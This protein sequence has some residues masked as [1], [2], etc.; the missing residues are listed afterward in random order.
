MHERVQLCQDPQT[1]FALLRESLGA[2]RTN[3]ILSVYG[4]TNLQEQRAAEFF[5]ELGQRSLEMLFPGFMEDSMVQATLNAD[6]SG[7]GHKKAR[8]IAAPAHLGALIAARPRIRALIQDAVLAGLLLQQRL[9]TRLDAVIATATSTYTTK[10]E[11]R[12]S[13]MFRKRPGQQRKRGSKQSGSIMGPAS[14]TRQCQTSNIPAPP[15][16]MT[17]VRI[18]TSQRTGRADS[19]HRRSKRSFHGCVIRLGSGV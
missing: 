15:L 18:W 4:Y 9:E 16:K 17:T 6:Q 11:P 14:Q 2:I 3:H 10:T 1:E 7:I 12:Q 13:C 5:D 19:M 8:G